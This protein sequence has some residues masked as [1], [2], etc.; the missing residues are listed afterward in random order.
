[1]QQ[2]T[3]RARTLVPG[4]DSNGVSPAA[5]SINNVCL[6]QSGL[7][8][9]NNNNCV[10]PCIQGN[11]SDTEKYVLLDV[12][13]G[14]Q[15]SAKYLNGIREICIT[16]NAA[17]LN[18]CSLVT[19]FKDQAGKENVDE[20]ALST[21][22]FPTLLNRTLKFST[23][24][25]SSSVFNVKVKITSTDKIFNL[26]MNDEP[27]ESESIEISNLQGDGIL[28][29]ITPITRYTCY[30]MKIIAKTDNTFALSNLF[31]S[32]FF[33]HYTPVNYSANYPLYYF[34]KQDATNPQRAMLCH[35][36]I[37]SFTT[38]STTSIANTDTTASSRPDNPRLQSVHQAFNLWS[39][40]DEDFQVV[41]SGQIYMIEQRIMDYYKELSSSSISWASKFPQQLF[42]VLKLDNKLDSVVNFNAA[43]NEY[44][45]NYVSSN[46][47]IVLKPL[48]LTDDKYDMVLSC[49]RKTDLGKNNKMK[50]LSKALGNSGSSITTATEPLYMVQT[51]SVIKVETTTLPPK[52]I[53]VLMPQSFIQAVSANKTDPKLFEQQLALNGGYSFKYNPNVDYSNPNLPPYV[54]PFNNQQLHADQMRDF[55][56]LPG[57]YGCVPVR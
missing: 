3:N 54:S 41:S 44:T 15:L 8:V 48:T 34:T 7:V 53:N 30:E 47:G 52:K 36:T 21:S 18:Y 25:S 43:K 4:I 17:K 9:N 38:S 27:A 32:E 35:Q 19:S 37:N 28:N 14:K 6:C 42:A 56:V 51:L 46:M 23:S 24:I 50:A 5:L 10:T 22:N 45:Q 57:I 40:M 16:A 49:P 2:T 26:L 29:T 13:I 33:Y 20:V 31:L 12:G 1:M 55:V 11:N 39:S